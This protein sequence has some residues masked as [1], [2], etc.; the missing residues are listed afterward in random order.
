MQ[1]PKFVCVLVSAIVIVGEESQLSDAVISIYKS[2]GSGIA[3]QE[4]KAFSGIPANAGAVISLIII[5]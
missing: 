2:G 1:I 5:C 4:T 3:S